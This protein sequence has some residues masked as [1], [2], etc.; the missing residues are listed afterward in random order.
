MYCVEDRVCGVINSLHKDSKI[1][2]NII[3]RE[4]LKQQQ[5][6]ELKKNKN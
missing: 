2:D 5:E 6:K 3:R 4:G 1:I